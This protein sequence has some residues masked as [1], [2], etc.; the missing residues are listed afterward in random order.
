MNHHRSSSFSKFLALALSLVGADGLAAQA[1][2]DPAAL[3]AGLDGVTAHV[4][5]L[6]DDGLE[7]RAVGTDGAR[8]AADYLAAQLDALGLEPAGGQGSWFQLFPIRKGAE[9]GPTNSLTVDDAPF[10]VGTDWVPFGFSASVEVTAELVFG[11]HGLSSPGNPE[12]RYAH[13]DL[14]GK[15]VVLEWGDPDAPHGVSLRADPHFKATVA[16]GRD[17]AGAVLLAPPGMGRPDI[18]SEARAALG[19]PIVVVHARRA[20]EVRAAAEA[21]AAVTLRADVREVEVDA[22]NVVALLP[23]SAPALR[24]EYVI[25]GA[26]YDH[27]GFGGEGSLAPDSREVHNGADDN[28]SGT[29]A[30]VEI[31]RALVEGERPERSVIWFPSP[32]LAISTW[33]PSGSLRTMS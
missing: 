31:A 15:V 3:T 23:G 13:L 2:P 17:A 18:A 12:D 4:R 16:A 33:A 1:C 29:A 20:D 9:L 24:D 22:R 19:I 21:G 7:G 8:C 27:L 14:T 5:Y 30:V 32:A 11:G 26:H 28:A 6:A 10:S 25:V